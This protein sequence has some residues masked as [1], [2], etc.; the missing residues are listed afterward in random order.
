[1]L[2]KNQVRRRNAIIAKRLYDNVSKAFEIY[3]NDLYEELGPLLL[4]TDPMA[5]KV[6]D[7]LSSLLAGLHKRSCERV[8]RVL[9]NFAQSVDVYEFLLF[10]RKTAPKMQDEFLRLL[11]KQATQTV[12]DMRIKHPVSGLNSETGEIYVED[13]LPCYIDLFYACVNVYVVQ[14][15]GLRL[16]ISDS[17]AM[18]MKGIFEQEYTSVAAFI[19]QFREICVA[20]KMSS[21]DMAKVFVKIYGIYDCEDQFGRLYFEHYVPWDVI[22][23]AKFRG[24]IEH[25]DLIVTQAYCR[26]VFGDVLP[27]SNSLVHR[28]RLMRKGGVKVIPNEHFDGL[29]YFV[30][31]ETHNDTE[32]YLT[33]DA[34]YYG[35]IFRSFAIDLESPFSIIDSAYCEIDMPLLMYVLTWLGLYD[36]IYNYLDNECTDERVS[37]AL[38]DLFDVIK[39]FLDKGCVYETPK[40]WNYIGKS[41]E[42]NRVPKKSTK[43][44]TS[45]EYEYVIRRVGAYVRKLPA[46]QKASPEKIEAAK[47]YYLELKDG[48][49]LVD[50]FERNQR[51]K[52][53]NAF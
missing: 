53:L 7:M 46:G 37:L 12:I 13:G 21:G 18:F 9:V 20:N 8:T 49:T 29:N 10:A 34:R 3:D 48:Y 30:V 31:S 44:S 2:T 43:V 17:D 45:S 47:R 24:L 5:D 26:L 36:S 23:L 22:N 6:Y 38:K 19:R 52:V 16:K 4:S 51:V 15:A 39:G 32:H 28:D 1:M 33:V 50:G 11:L 27:K 25:Q 42:F 14:D 41:T 35:T 40:S